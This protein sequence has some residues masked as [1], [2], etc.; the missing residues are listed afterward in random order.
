[1]HTL[2]QV[3]VGASV[4]EIGCGSGQLALEL[5]EKGISNYLGV[6]I[7]PEMINIAQHKVISKKFKFIATDFLH[8]DS[9]DRF[10]YAILP[11]IVHSIDTNTVQQIILKSSTLA[12]KIII[13]DY[14][15]PQPRNSK[16]LLVRIIEWLEGNEH[17]S[18]FKKFQKNGGALFYA[19][20]SGYKT[21]SMISHHVFEIIVLEPRS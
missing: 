3:E 5:F 15:S 6:D 18:N 4:L 21:L 14:S 8:L 7:A 12:N 20:P 11:M 17:Y 19:N 2:S 13:A 1:M 10:D 16:A 9:S